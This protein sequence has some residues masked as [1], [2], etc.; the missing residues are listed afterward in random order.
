MENEN[1]V[2]N[3]IRKYIFNKVK[4]S[5]THTVE[6][7]REVAETCLI[8]AFVDKNIEENFKV[9]LNKDGNGYVIELK[10]N[11]KVLTIDMLNQGGLIML[12]LADG[13][14]LKDVPPDSVTEV[15]CRYAVEQNH[16][17]L[18]Y[19]PERFMTA[20]LFE[21]ALQSYLDRNFEDRKLLVS[22]SEA[23]D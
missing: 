21:F 11:E 14:N 17:A 19:V 23:K 22:V 15:I 16:S 5:G 1:Y 10:D 8:D 6:K 7:I 13:L 3:Q 12:M 20:A 18:H 9:V 4:E 2:L